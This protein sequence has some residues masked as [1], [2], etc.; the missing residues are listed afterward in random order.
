MSPVYTAPQKKVTRPPGR[1]PGNATSRRDLRKSKHDYNVVLRFL[2]IG[3]F[4]AKY[5][6]MPEASASTSS[7]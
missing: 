2:A 4:F 3:G 1:T 5:L 6:A 7:S